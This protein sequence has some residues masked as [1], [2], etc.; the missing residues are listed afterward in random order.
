[1]PQKNSNAGFYDEQQPKSY[2]QSKQQVEEDSDSG[3][4][5]EYYDEEDE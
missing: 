4:D 1:M 3:E 2:K 5:F